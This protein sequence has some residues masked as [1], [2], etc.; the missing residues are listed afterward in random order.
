MNIEKEWLQHFKALTISLFLDNNTT[1]DNMQ[2]ERI[3]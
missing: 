1:I 2:M 3:I